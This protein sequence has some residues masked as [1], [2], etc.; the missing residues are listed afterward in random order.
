[1]DRAHEATKNLN[2]D[3]TNKNNENP[4]AE[5]IIENEEMVDDT[6]TVVKMEAAQCSTNVSNH[7]LKKFK[8]PK[9]SM[10]T[11]TTKHG[12]TTENVATAAALPM[13]ILPTNAFNKQIIKTEPDVIKQL[14][15]EKI[16]RTVQNVCAV[17]PLTQQQPTYQSQSNAITQNSFETLKPLMREVLQLPT[18]S[19][20]EDEDMKSLKAVDDNK[21]IVC[22][23]GKFASIKGDSRN[24]SRHTIVIAKTFGV[25]CLPF[26]V[27]RCFKLGNCEFSHK[28]REPEAVGKILLTFS[29]MDLNITYRFAYNHESLFRRYMHEFCRVYS[30][31]NNRIKLLN[32]ARDC[33]RYPE[34]SKLLATIFHS[35]EYC[36]L[37][38]MNACRQILSYS[39]DRSQET[40]DLL[41]DIILES[42]W[43]M[44]CD[45]IEKFI[46]ITSYKF[47]VN[48]LH[49]MA[50]TILEANDQRMTSLF[51]KCLVNLDS[52]DVG[53]VQ[54]SPILMQLLELI[55]NGQICR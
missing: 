12:S 25:T 44:F 37:N 30:L 39:Q 34:G 42:D 7:V 6:N 45:H 29:E 8:I 46:G 13:V 19:K 53:L 32:M 24:S 43:T 23:N 35:L 15:L 5:N 27:D 31:R 40:I 52:N 9:I 21:Q 47:R 49:Q 33:E 1:M 41:L 54:S 14:N 28:F 48:V 26:L 10:T 38:K 3:I 18:S 20:E 50:P 2:S 22:K 4:Q 11:A 51:F 17:T 36:G 16:T 55:K